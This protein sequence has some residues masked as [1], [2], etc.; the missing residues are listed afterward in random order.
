ME[1]LEEKGEGLNQQVKL[2]IK[3]KRRKKNFIETQKI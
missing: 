2:M 3:V 1:W